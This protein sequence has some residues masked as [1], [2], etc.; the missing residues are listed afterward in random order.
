MNEWEAGRAFVAGQ[1]AGVAL[2]FKY[3][4]DLLRQAATLEEFIE[5]HVR[6]FVGWDYLDYG[7]LLKPVECHLTAIANERGFSTLQEY[8]NAK[9]EGYM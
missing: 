6:E 7:A 8:W 9:V 3:K 2:L 5:G 4:H 1:V